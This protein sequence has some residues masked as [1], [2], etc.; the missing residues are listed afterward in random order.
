MMDPYPQEEAPHENAPNEKAP[1]EKA[2][3]EKASEAGSAA[4]D[5]TS[6]EAAAARLDAH[7]DY[8]VL[9]RLPEDPRTDGDLGAPFRFALYV[10]VETTGMDAAKDAI[11]ELAMVLFGYDAHGRITGIEARFDQLED[12][13]RRIPTEI[14]ELTGITDDDV[15][16]RR[17]DE[18]AA[19]ELIARA[20]L[21]VAHN[22]KFDRAF[23]ER[24]FA[25]FRDLPWACSADDVPWRDEGLESRKLEFLAYRFGFF[26][27]G[28]RA[29]T[30]CVAGVH[31]LSRLLPKGGL[32]AMARLLEAARREEIL[33][34]AVGAPFESKD[35]LKARGYR[36]RP[37][38]K[39]WWKC[40]PDV[41]AEA[42]RSWLGSQ[43]YG[44]TCRA[45]EAPITA[46]QRYSPRAR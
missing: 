20:N 46:Y 26:Y 23:L 42:E 19:A 12:P 18:D 33:F 22:A 9:R 5:G 45:T 8:L 24:R 29:V 2:P 39:C 17:I 38:Q 21:V 40:V 35:L 3:H 36:W 16:G 31:V 37:D 14:T 7:P 27:D 28:H 41:A 15:R 25:P 30:D 11:I 44:G 13:G 32:P 10:D 4:S 1:N 34:R 6:L 43:V